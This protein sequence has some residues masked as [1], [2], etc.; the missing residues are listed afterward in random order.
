MLG[1]TA[2]MATSRALKCGAS[3]L[4]LG[5]ALLQPTAAFAQS[6]P[7]TE[8]TTPTSGSTDPNATAPD[9]PGSK[10]AIIVT[11]VRKALQNAAQRK[12]NADTVVDS[13]TATDIGAFPD[14]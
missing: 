4:G 1:F 10:N 12:K 7:T 14:K 13:I 9:E 8:A 11:G 2:R 5:A 3:T 6:T